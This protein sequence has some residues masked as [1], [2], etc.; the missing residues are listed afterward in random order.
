MTFFVCVYAAKYVALPLLILPRKRLNRYV[1]KGF[2]IEGANITTS[3][4]GFIDYTLF[5]SWIGFFSNSVPDSVVRLLFL[6]YDFFFS[7][8]NDEI[9]KKAV[10]LKVVSV[11]LPDNFTNYIQPLYTSVFKTFNLVLKTVLPNLML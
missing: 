10:E 7:H 8:Y 6:V 9:V 2:Y 4:K 5:L 1:L 11:L 3:P